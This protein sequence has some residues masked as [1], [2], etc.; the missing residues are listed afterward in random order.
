MLSCSPK[1]SEYLGAVGLYNVSGL[2]LMLEYSC[3]V[4][5]LG[6]ASYPTP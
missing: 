6:L 1:I 4:P 2:Q 3:P 5:L